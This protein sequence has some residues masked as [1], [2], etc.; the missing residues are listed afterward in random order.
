MTGYWVPQKAWDSA[1]NACGIRHI[2]RPYLK[3]SFWI[4]FGSD[5][6]IKVSNQ[7]RK[8][9]GSVHLWLPAICLPLKDGGISLSAFPNGTS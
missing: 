4:S 9:V 2:P 3:R 6:E 5:I 8:N 7:D 1:G